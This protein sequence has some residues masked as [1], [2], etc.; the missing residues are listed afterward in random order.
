MITYP[1]TI[2]EKEQVIFGDS[3][4]VGEYKGLENYTYDYV[5]G[6]LHIAFTLSHHQCCTAAYPPSL[7]ITNID[8]T[9]TTTI[10]TREDA[11]IFSLHAQPDHLTGVYFY[12]IQFDSAGYNAVVTAS[13]TEVVNFHKNIL[14][15]ATSTDYVA[16]HNHYP[17]QDP[18]NQ[19]S[20]SF[21]PVPLYQVPTTPSVATTTPVIIVPGIISSRLKI[22]SQEIWPDILLMTA[23]IDDIH[24]NDLIMNNSGESI[25]DI[26]TSTIIRNIGNYNFFN[27]L[28]SSLDNIDLEENEDVFEFPYDWRLDVE[29]TVAKLKDKIE[30]VK[31]Q[32]GVGR[33]NLIAHSMGGLIV[34]KYLKDYGG[35]SADKF[36]DIGT[37]HTG[38]PKTFKILSYGDN[39]GF[40]KFGLD[41]LNSNRVKAISQNMPAV[42][43]LL[44]SQ[45]YF[46]NEEY[47]V[48][49]G[50]SGNNRLDFSETKSYLKSEGRNSALVD[51]A[52]AFHQEIDNLNPADYG[53]ETYNFVGCGVP[54][55]GKFYILE[56]GTHPIYNIG[57]INGDGTV[58]FESANNF[59]A[60]KTYYVKDAKHALMPSTSGVRELVAEILS[61]TSTADFNISPYSNISIS[62]GNCAFPDG[63]VISLHSPIELHIYD[64][65]GNHV[66]PDG[67]G[68][69]ENEIS[70]VTYEV[71]DDNKFAFLP[72]GINY[73]VKGS[74]TGVGTFDVRIQE[75]VDEKVATTTLWTDVALASTTRVQ[76]SVNSSTPNLY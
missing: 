46:D 34:K 36:I 39:F 69:I 26:S 44:P 31:T 67:N 52:D 60:T 22:G 38:A 49:D 58:P 66:G 6:Y 16:L 53:V 37:P 76:F 28:F 50:T 18:I 59:P 55:I 21:T 10:L 42:Y 72:D 11:Y 54:T 8:P 12:D 57:Y 5:G 1:Y 41:I 33:V 32:R 63:R 7:Y 56:N 35:S 71:I 14:G 65:S 15:I 9:S 61:A 62:S 75:I 25:S 45:N 29:T 48:L 24:L 68:D 27:G 43:Q 20:M 74:A 19:S 51:R 64:S 2:D 40:E 30:E 3:T 70:G 47:Y 17:R 4:Q 23:S 73:T 13:S